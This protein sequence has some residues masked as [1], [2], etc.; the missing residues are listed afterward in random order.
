LI[1]KKVT[2]FLYAELGTHEKKI[3]RVVYYSRPKFIREIFRVLN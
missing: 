1:E 3:N 2:F